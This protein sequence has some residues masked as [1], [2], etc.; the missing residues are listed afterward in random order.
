MQRP[1]KS[2]FVAQNGLR[3]HV[4]DQRQF[5][6]YHQRKDAWVAMHDSTV[7]PR[8]SVVPRCL[9]A[10][11]GRPAVP[12]H[13]VRRRRLGQALHSQGRGTS[14]EDIDRRHGLIFRCWQGFWTD[15]DGY[16]SLPP[17]LLSIDELAG[18]KDDLAQLFRI[19][20]ALA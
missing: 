13:D 12:A 16:Y 10:L 3:V 5:R 2:D 4:L 14:T 9:Q 17:Q 19:L 20:L 6:V 8:R 15:L 11:T 1:L 18:T 7:R